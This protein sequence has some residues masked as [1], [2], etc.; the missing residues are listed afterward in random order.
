MTN[1][2]FRTLV[3]KYAVLIFIGYSLTFLIST[4]IQRLIPEANT[5]NSSIIGFL[6][7]ST[8]I[9]QLIINIIAAILVSKDMKRLDIKNNLIVAMTVLF[10][11]I[12]ITMFF[13]TANREIKNAST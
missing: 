12:G 9:I 3:N 8:W 7:S 1:K 4:I 6:S 13:I 5:G 10:S 2:N 11:L